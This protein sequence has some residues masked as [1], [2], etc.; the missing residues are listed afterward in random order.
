ME[1]QRQKADSK[2][3]KKRKGRYYAKK[4]FLKAGSNNGSQKPQNDV[5]QNSKRK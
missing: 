1:Q 2:S 3:S 4:Y 5:F